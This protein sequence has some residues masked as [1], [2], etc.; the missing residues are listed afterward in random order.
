M[1]VNKIDNFFSSNGKNLPVEKS[2]EIR[3]KL[4][5][6]D[7]KR[8]ATISSVALKDTTTML[9]ISIFLGGFAVDRFMLGKTGSGI[10]KL[11]LGYLTLGIWWLVDICT[12]TKQTREYN[13]NKLMQAV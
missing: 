4:E 2:A 11:L 13:Y 3:E 10:A 1:D 7:D 12:I 9:L 6:V 5:A 8:Y